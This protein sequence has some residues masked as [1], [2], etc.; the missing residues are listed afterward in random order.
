EPVADFSLVAAVD[1]EGAAEVLRLFDTIAATGATLRVKGAGALAAAARA[2]IETG[3]DSQSVASWRL[4][5]YGL[6]LL[7]QTQQ[8]DDLSIDYC[9]TFE[10]S[11]PPWE[12]VPAGIL[13]GDAEKPSA[14]DEP[15]DDPPT[16]RSGP[17]T[18]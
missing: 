2:A 18:R 13:A 7:G 1:A 3:G 10:V 16:T 4:A 6:R 9:V 14:R 17:P 11:P 15:S 5:L 12:P 8:F